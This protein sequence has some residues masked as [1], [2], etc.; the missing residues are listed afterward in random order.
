MARGV[1]LLNGRVYTQQETQPVARA[2]ALVGNRIASVGSDEE[3]L[4]AAGPTAEPIDLGGR[5][6]VP[7]FVDAHFHVLEY[8]LDRDR[9]QLD[10]AATLDGVLALVAEAARAAPAGTW[11]VGRGW[12]RNLWPEARFPTRHDLDRVTDRRPACLFSR[13]VHA[14]WA[15]TAALELAGIGLDTPDPPGGKIVREPD[16][17]PSGILLEAAAGLVRALADRPS[18]EASVALLRE[19]QQELARLG[20]TALHNFEG[21]RTFEALQVLDARGELG[22]RVFAGSSR[23][24]LEATARVGPRAGFGG[25]RLRVGLLKLFADGALGVGTAAMLAPY[26]GRPDD[27]GI[28]TLELQELVGLIRRAREAGVGVATHAIGDAAVRLVLDAAAVVRADDHPER[29][30]QILRVEHAQL[31]HPDDVPRFARLGVVASMQ[32]LHATSDMRTADR[33]WG[34]RCRTGYAWRSLLDAGARLAFGTD[35]PVEP[36][37]PLLSIHAAVTRQRDGEPPEGWYPEQRLTVAEAIRAYTLGSAAAAGL[38]HEHGSIAPGRLAD[39]AVLSR[40]PYRIPP[41][42]LADV[43]VAMTIFDGQVVHDARGE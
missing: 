13:D 37:N 22:L 2:V 25:E 11:V 18:L 24:D 5:A 3:A 41:P 12:D 7:G 26:E 19:G 9:V 43:T 23:D 42:E 21:A 31:V 38:A 40:D 29:A 6:V 33:D 32:P 28:A 17:A 27:R 4:E 39:L 20:L 16:G 1:A 36:P 35:C 10:G 8:C 30:A 15:N 34:T 14:V